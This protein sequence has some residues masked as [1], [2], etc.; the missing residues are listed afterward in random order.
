MSHRIDCATAPVN[1]T[2]ISAKNAH[3]EVPILIAKILDALGIKNI[4]PRKLKRSD[5]LYA[6]CGY[7]NQICLSLV[8]SL[9]IH[10]D[11]LMVVGDNEIITI[12]DAIDFARDT[13]SMR[14]N[15]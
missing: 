15:D 11:V 7:H 4:V 8:R 10:F 13:L 2:N 9:M 3:K 6:L 12:G 14:E 1:L 5:N